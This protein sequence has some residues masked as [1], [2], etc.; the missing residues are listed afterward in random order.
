MS[1]N[2][3]T[4]RCAAKHVHR[5]RVATVI[6]VAIGGVAGSSARVFIPWPMLFGQY[7]GLVDPLPSVIVNLIGAALLGFVTGYSRHRQWSQPLSKGI[8]TGFLG[9]FTTM[10][11]L[12]VAYSGLTLGQSVLT[13]GSAFQGLVFG[14]GILAGLAGFLLCTT[15]V[16][17]GALTLG[18]KTAQDP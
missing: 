6:A 16:T 1:W 4:P 11:A 7:M 18:R 3:L 2:D 5:P 12:A 17:M 10:S 8:T 15:L 9:S 14:V 13:E